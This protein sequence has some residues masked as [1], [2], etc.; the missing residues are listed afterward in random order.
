MAVSTGAQRC[1]PSSSQTKAFGPHVAPD[2]EP[3][4]VPETP[5][6]EAPVA[7]DPPLLLD[8]PSARSTPEPEPAVEG[9]VDPELHAASIRVKASGPLES[10]QHSR[11]IMR[12]FL[13]WKRPLPS[14]TH[15]DECSLKLVERQAGNRS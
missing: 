1:T 4:P 11:A 9:E 3:E 10:L 7:P 5:P 12:G 2:P 8:P 15:T 13:A 6:E 14:R